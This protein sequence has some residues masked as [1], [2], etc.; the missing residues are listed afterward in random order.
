[1]KSGKEEMG[2]RTFNAL[3]LHLLVVVDMAAHGTVRL[4]L[5]SQRRLN[6]G[7]R[8]VA[9]DKRWESRVIWTVVTQGGG[10]RVG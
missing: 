10:K 7:A 4:N 5:V 9:W 1:V 2:G 6:W 3:L 8:V